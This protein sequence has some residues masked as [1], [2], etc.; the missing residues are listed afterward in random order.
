MSP[1]AALET[2]HSI[3]MA[4]VPPSVTDYANALREDGLMRGDRVLTPGGWQRIERLVPGDR[5]ITFDNGP[6]EIVCI[7]ETT[8]RRSKLP[9]HKAFV[10]RVPAGALNNDGLLRLLPN[11]EV[12]IES[13]SAEA[14]TGDPFVLMPSVLLAG[15]RGIEAER[16]ED[17]IP[18]FMPTFRDEQIVQINDGVWIVCRA[19]ADFSPFETAC[20][21]GTQGAY[22]RLDTTF[23]V[24]LAQTLVSG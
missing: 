11:Q 15:Y 1:I 7:H 24:N 9:F 6:Q 14:A 5:V 22:P 3:P 20:K 21:P 12:M 17:D 18:L 13:D 4:S 16:F 19:E 10:M 23:L 8:I 2:D